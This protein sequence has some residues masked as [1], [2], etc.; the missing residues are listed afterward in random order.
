MTRHTQDKCFCVQGYITWHKLYGKPKLKPKYLNPAKANNV[1]KGTMLQ[2]QTSTQINVPGQGDPTRDICGF[3]KDHYQ[4]LL[5]MI[6]KTMKV[7]IVMVV[8]AYLPILSSLKLPNGQCALVTL[9]R[10]VHLSSDLIL[11]QVLCDL[12]WKKNKGIGRVSKGL[13]LLNPEFLPSGSSSQVKSNTP[14]VCSLLSSSS[15]TNSRNKIAD[16]WHARMGHVPSSVL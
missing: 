7:Q 15:R 5:K 1:S 6:Q 2:D 13:Y 10:D 9:I 16:M 14:Q 4:Q 11:Y 12:T 3:S 8:A